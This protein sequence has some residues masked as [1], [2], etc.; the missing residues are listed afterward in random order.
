VCVCVCVS[1][2]LAGYVVLN[3]LCLCIGD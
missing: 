3:H 1:T 2:G